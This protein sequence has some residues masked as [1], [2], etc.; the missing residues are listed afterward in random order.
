MKFNAV[1]SRSNHT[2]VVYKNSVYIFGGAS[3]SKTKFNDTLKLDTTTHRISQLRVTGQ[4]PE[5]RTYHASACIDRYMIVLGGEGE[6]DLGD[7]YALDLE[8]RHWT[9]LHISGDKFSAR[10]FHT[11]V[12][13]GNKL[14]VFGGCKDEYSYDYLNEVWEFDFED[15]VDCG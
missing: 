6:E 10:R 14:Y 15:F 3:S 1:L 8:T 5:E 9:K 12:A 11:A 4:V 2:A 13:K 7:L